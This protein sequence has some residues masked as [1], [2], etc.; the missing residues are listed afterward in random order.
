MRRQFQL[1]EDDAR[2]LEG[3][4]LPWETVSVAGVNWLLVHEFPVPPGYDHPAVTLAVRIEVAYPPGR[5]DM[6]YVHPALQRVDGKRIDALAA[7]A[8]DGQAYQ[9][10]SRHY[11]WNPAEHDLSTHVACA[12]HWLENEFRKR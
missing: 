9:R 10:W 12:Q 4:G 1:P 11:E 6:V 5:L 2:F 7:E 3:L 8:I